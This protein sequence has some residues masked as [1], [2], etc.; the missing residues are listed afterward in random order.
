MGTA[1]DDA[2]AVEQALGAHLCRCTGWRTIVD[3]YAAYGTDPPAARDLDAAARRATLEGG[4]S[5]RVDPVVVLGAGGF[6]D[7]T[8]PPDALVAVPDAR[9]RLGRR[10]E[11]PRR[12]GP[13]RQGPGRR[14][15][16]EPSHPLDVPPGDWDRSLRTTWVEPAYLE[17]D[18]SW[19]EPGGEPATPLANGGAFGGKTGASSSTAARRLADE[20]GRA[21]RV[22]ALAR[23]RR[24]S[25]LQA[26]ADRRG[27][28]GGRVRSRP[29]RRRRRASRSCTRATPRT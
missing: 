19:C 20:H 9:R 12:P 2:P 5:Q 11:R 1:P 6:A 26:S 3:A 7:D 14:T 27:R 10:R 23:G 13:V 8:A 4:V 17:L 25:R 22:S 28:P 18:A 16:V 21:V 29:D 15:T 24:A